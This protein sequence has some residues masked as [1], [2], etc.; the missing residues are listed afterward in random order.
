[1]ENQTTQFFIVCYRGKWVKIPVREPMTE[2]SFSAKPLTKGVHQNIESMEILELS[3]LPM[4]EVKKICTDN[5]LE[6]NWII[7]QE[8]KEFLKSKLIQ[9]S[10]R[11]YKRK[12]EPLSLDERKKFVLKL[13]EL[14]EKA[15]LIAE[16]II[17]LNDQLDDSDEYITLEE[18]LRLKTSAVETDEVC[19]SITLMRCGSHKTH[20]ITQMLPYD[21][22]ESLLKIIDP[23][24]IY[25]FSTP[26]DTLLSP[27]NVNRIFEQAGASSL[28]LRPI[29]KLRQ[30]RIYIPIQ[31]V[32]ED[33]RKELLEDSYKEV[34]LKEWEIL[35]KTCPELRTTTGRPSK[36]K[37][38]EK[39][40]A[41]LF[42]LRT[43]TSLRN[44]PSNYPPYTTIEPQLRRW[45]GINSIKKILN[46]RL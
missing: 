20:L 18:V 27:G 5:E 15:A 14:N 1:M 3:T 22:E 24:A 44:L 40:N 37:P 6:L 23:N 7:P 13:R 21:L 4:K 31:K 10:S 16:I 45:G 30:S 19:T 46:S 38:I 39:F 33:I 12:Y 29:P 43:G 2:T 9:G 11:R 28:S 25:V 34:N 32:S 17:F 36:H 35:C 42:H 8:P 26:D 41:I